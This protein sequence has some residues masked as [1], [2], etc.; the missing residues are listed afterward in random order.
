MPVPPK[1]TIQEHAREQ[2]TF[3]ENKLE[4]RLEQARLGLRQVDFVDTAHPGKLRLPPRIEFI[5]PFARGPGS[6]RGG[7]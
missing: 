2:A 4:P 1:Q 5:S 6:A 3:L 7:A